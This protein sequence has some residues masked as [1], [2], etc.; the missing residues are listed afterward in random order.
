MALVAVEEALLLV[1]TLVDL[2]D[3]VASTMEQPNS[4]SRTDQS[5]THV[6]FPL[7]QSKV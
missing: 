3:V 4:E 2:E 7:V 5:M 6:T 1:A